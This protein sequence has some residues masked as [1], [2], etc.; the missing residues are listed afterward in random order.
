MTELIAISHSP[1]TDAFTLDRLKEGQLIDE[2][3]AAGVV[4]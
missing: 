4:R 3:V 2:S 1:L